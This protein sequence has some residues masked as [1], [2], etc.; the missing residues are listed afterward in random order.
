[1]GNVEFS[2]YVELSKKLFHLLCPTKSQEELIVSIVILLQEEIS[3]ESIGLRF[4]DGLDYP[5][6]FTQGFSQDFVQKEMY[7]CAHDPEER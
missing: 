2:N 6:Y 7:L 1:M 4:K 5:Y 3:V